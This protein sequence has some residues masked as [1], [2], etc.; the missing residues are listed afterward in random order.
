[1]N[2]LASQL[3]CVKSEKMLKFL[4]LKEFG[5]WQFLIATRLAAVCSGLH[6]SKVVRGRNTSEQTS[7]S[8]GGYGSLMHV[9]ERRLSSP[10]DE[11][12]WLKLI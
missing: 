12:L 4:D 1:M 5:R 3:R 9:G 7:G 11:L 2:I 6:R 8:W 10:A